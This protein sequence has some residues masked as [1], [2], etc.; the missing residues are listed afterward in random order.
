MQHLLI[1]R[2]NNE[3]TTNLTGFHKPVRFLL[4]CCQVLSYLILINRVPEAIVGFTSFIAK[5]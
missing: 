4:T 1:G 3:N 2:N 5:L